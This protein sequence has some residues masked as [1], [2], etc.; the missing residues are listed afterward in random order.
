MSESDAELL[1]DDPLRAA[2]EVCD[3]LQENND[4]EFVYL[5]T[6]LFGTKGGADVDLRVLCAQYPTPERH[7][8]IQERFA[9]VPELDLL[10]ITV[11][12]LERGGVTDLTDAG[13]VEDHLHHG[14]DPHKGQ[15]ATGDTSLFSLYIFA[16]LQPFHEPSD[17]FLPSP[18]DAL[19]KVRLTEDGAIGWAHF[20]AG[21]FIDERGAFM[22]NE[23]SS[24]TYLARL[25]K[26]LVRVTVGSAL[27]QL[28]QDQLAEVKSL[29]ATAIQE[30]NELRSTDE[31]MVGVMLAY[32]PTAATLSEVTKEQLLLAAGLRS[33][34]ALSIPEEDFRTQAEAALF[35]QAYRQGIERRL[36]DNQEVDYLTSYAFEAL[37]RTRPDLARRVMLPAEAMF[38]VQGTKGD[39]FYYIPPKTTQH[40]DNPQISIIVDGAEYRKSHPGN[41]YGELAGLFGAVRSASTVTTGPTE[42]YQISG[43]KIRA[44]LGDPE[45]VKELSGSVLQPNDALVADVLLRYLARE[46]GKFLRRVHT[47]A[48]LPAD[49]ASARPENS[50]LAQYD[51]GEAFYTALLPFVTGEPDA[52]VRVIDADSLDGGRLFEAHV[53]NTELFVAAPGSLVEIQLGNG[54]TFKLEP[55]AVF[56]ESAF[57]GEL[58]AGSATIDRGGSVLAINADWFKKFTQTRSLIDAG[59]SR[60]AGIRATQLLYHLAFQGYARVIARVDQ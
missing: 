8:E 32:G 2:F 21:C 10:Y 6:Y 18:Q 55:N 33:G 22:Q 38:L 56:G 47:Q 50:P 16:T 51:L 59:P 26:F 17:G 34:R 1:R 15:A 23:L 37:L 31:S 4:D 9:G 30:S 39:G 46:S 40:E 7:A 13:R 49:S 58:T 25:A 14:F 27:A 43:K 28:D 53:R 29:L 44:L 20:Y 24:D 19:D 45:V 41:V 54:E 5:G 42:A 36:A 60:P 57:L 48:S 35:Y 12:E 3:A 11:P 52:P